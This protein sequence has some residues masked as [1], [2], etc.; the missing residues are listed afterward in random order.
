MK[1]R[2]EN[3]V[4][5]YIHMLR[6]RR[7]LSSLRLD[8]R[9]GVPLHVQVERLL[10][11]LVRRNEY[12]GGRPLPDE[13]SLAR[14][15]GVSR[16]TVRAGMARLVFEGLVERRAG[17]GTR[18][19][20]PRPVT[21]GLSSWQS[22]TREMEAK[23]LSVRTFSLGTEWEPAGKEAARGLGIAAGTRVLRLDRL[24]GWGGEP[25]VH[26][27]SWFHP[28]LGLTGRE[29]F[30]RPLYALIEDCCGIVAESSHEELDA[31]GA[32]DG[33][34]RLLGVRPGTPLLKRVRT[35]TDPGG[36]PIEYAVVH[37]RSDRFTLTLDIRRDRE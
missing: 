31:V 29:D 17:V 16:S 1:R 10:R 27:R 14:R 19:V 12:R 33:M 37:Y 11:D 9:A 15:L 24:R 6:A 18:A 23:G 5:M 4:I 36:K 26:F 30:E 28:R 32:D 20:S 21:S 35:V 7:D 22:F 3:I 34:A 13:V 2:A 25:V 8:R